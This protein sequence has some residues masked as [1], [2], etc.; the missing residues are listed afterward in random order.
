LFD[1]IISSN[2]RCKTF[3]SE[4]NGFGRAEGVAA[5]ILKRYSD[6]VANG[7]NI[8]GLICGSAVVQEGP[9]KMI[10]TLTVECKAL[11]MTLA[12]E[13]AEVHP[14]EVSYVETHWTGTPV[15]DPLEIAAI[16]KAY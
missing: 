2:G 12:F 15:G 5:L 6:A 1:G 14:I 3:D 11:A 13:R 7:D 16:T 8:W 4:A 10:G 9:S